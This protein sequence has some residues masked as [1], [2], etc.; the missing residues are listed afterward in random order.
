MGFARFL[1]TSKSG[2][3]L[4]SSDKTLLPNSGK[5]S[6]NQDVSKVDTHLRERLLNW[7]VRDKFVGIIER[8]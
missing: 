3:M 2:S 6:V 5:L 7:L 8:N 4:D 1:P